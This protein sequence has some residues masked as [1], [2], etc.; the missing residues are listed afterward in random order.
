MQDYVHH[1][2][3]VISSQDIAIFTSNVHKCSEY[4]NKCQNVLGKGYCA[5]KS[6]RDLVNAV[7][8]RRVKDMASTTEAEC[9]VRIFFIIISC[10][11]HFF[12]PIVYVNIYLPSYP[13]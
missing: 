7:R 2:C 3:S 9:N 1:T 5:F 10:S 8:S 6:E 4:K 11:V 13:L 12:A